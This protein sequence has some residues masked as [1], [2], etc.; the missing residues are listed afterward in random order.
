[1]VDGLRSRYSAN[2]LRLVRRES[3]DTDFDFVMLTLEPSKTY[4]F[5][6]SSKSQQLFANFGMLFHAQAT[7]RENDFYGEYRST[8]SN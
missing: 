3:V 2:V 6:N 5:K 8:N 4:F 1:M 7:A